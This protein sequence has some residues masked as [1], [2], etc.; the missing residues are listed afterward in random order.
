MKSTKMKTSKKNIDRVVT[1]MYVALISMCMMASQAMSQTAKDADRRDADSTA[2]VA[3]LHKQ[4]QGKRP[5]TVAAIVAHR[6]F[7]QTP[8]SAQNSLTA[9][10]KAQELGVYSS[11]TDCWLTADNHIVQNHDGKIGDT[12]LRNVTFDE[13]K[14]LRLANCEPVPQLRDMLRSVTESPSPTIL[15]IEIKEHDTKKRTLQCARLVA[16]EVKRCG[17]GNKVEFT[18]FN[19]DACR[20]LQKM[21]PNATVYYLKGGMAPADVMK[22][23]INGLNYN[24]KE[25]RDNPQWVDEAHK[26]GMKMCVWTAENIHDMV[27]MNVRGVDLMS[28][29]RPA[30]A[31]MVRNIIEQER[32]T[33]TEKR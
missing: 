31:M 33:S 11:E 8:G 7:W 16:K 10:R 1:K 25:V 22:L 30:L 15:R 18:S 17:A 6:G 32:N 28:S 3:T 19:L 9:L 29:N 5:S 26:L 24:I 13:V 12:V 4:L 23:G 20:E 21:F 2:I 14:K 27:E